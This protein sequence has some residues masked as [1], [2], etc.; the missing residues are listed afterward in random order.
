MSIK[1]PDFLNWPRLNAL[2]HKMKAPLSISFSLDPIQPD[3]SLAEKLLSGI[4]EID[5][6]EVQTHNDGTLF[7]NNKRVLL[8]IR[9]ILPAAEMPKYH[10]TNCQSLD[11]MRKSRR[12]DRYVVANRDTGEFIVN[13]IGSGEKNLMV[14]LD[15]CQNCL[16]RIQWRGFSRQNMSSCERRRRVADFSLAEFFEE[17]PR[18]LI[19][20]KPRFTSATSPLNDYPKNWKQLSLEVRRKRGFKCESCNRSFKPNESRFLHVHHRNGLKYDNSNLN[21]EVL[22]IACHAEKPMHGHLKTHPDYKTLVT[23]P[24]I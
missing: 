24:L 12:F 11:S 10:I 19:T 22:C 8:H 23:A 5:L 14:K 1:L 13:N 15:V 3:T 17:Y 2:R 18:D 21:L 20:T 9:D 4:H 16:D 6:N 7:Y